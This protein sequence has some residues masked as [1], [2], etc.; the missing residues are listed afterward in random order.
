[1]F[2][3]ASAQHFKTFNRNIISCLFEYI[4][5]KRKIDLIIRKTTACRRLSRFIYRVNLRTIRATEGAPVHTFSI[6][7]VLCVAQHERCKEK[8]DHEFL[9]GDEEFSVPA[10]LVQ[11][12]NPSN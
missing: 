11:R 9:G 3:F 10:L 4:L 5:H 1:M 2:A 7:V 8:R 12:V 6:S